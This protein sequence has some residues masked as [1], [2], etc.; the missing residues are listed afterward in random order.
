MKNMMERDN[1]PVPT[2]SANPQTHLI[3]V[4]QVEDS[5]IGAAGSVGGSYQ[6]SRSQAMTIATHIHQTGATQGG[7][8]SR[9]HSAAVLNNE[10][11][12]HG[13]VMHD[14]SD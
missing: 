5:K 11:P 4:Q 8:Y 13:F 12:H 10:T 1:L 2:H 3:Q 14:P 6:A 7:T 9:D